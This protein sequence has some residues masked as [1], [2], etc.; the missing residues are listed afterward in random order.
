MF[1]TDILDNSNNSDVMQKKFII[2]TDTP[3]TF[4]LD[5][6]IVHAKWLQKEARESGKANLEIKTSY[7]GEGA[8]IRITIYTSN[9][10]KLAKI[11]GTVSI[12][13][14]RTMFNIPEKVNPGESLFFE[15]ILPKHGIS[16]KSD[17]IP[18]KPG[19]NVKNMRW[20]KQEVHRGEK[21]SIICEFD[22]GVTDNDPVDVKIFEYSDNN[23]HDRIT[24]IPA[25][26]S[27][28]KIDVQWICEY[29][30]DT[31]K[32]PTDEEL[33]KFGKQYKPPE[34]FF[35]VTLDSEIIGTNQKSG[36][37]RFRDNVELKITNGRIERD[38]AQEFVITLPD[39]SEVKRKPDSN[40]S[41]VIN[42]LDPGKIKISPTDQSASQKHGEVLWKTGSGAEIIF[43]DHT[44]LIDSHMH[45]QSNNCCPLTMQW[46]LLAISAG[47]RSNSDRKKLIDTTSNLIVSLLAT[48][49]LGKIGRLSSDLIARLYM[50]ELKDNDM[51]V[52]LSW[53]VLSQRKIENYNNNNQ[54]EQMRIIAGKKAEL[55]EMTYSSLTDYNEE[56][57]KETA[58]YFHGTRLVRM[59]F[60]MSMDM[61]YGSYWGRSGIPIYIKSDNKMLYINDFVSC[62]I[63]RDQPDTSFSVSLNEFTVT[64]C[65]ITKE[66]IDATKP[67]YISTSPQ[68][69]SGT[70]HLYP[71]FFTNEV[72]DTNGN[73]FYLHQFDLFN[74]SHMI[75]PPSDCIPLVKFQNTPETRTLAG[76]KYVH[77]VNI[78]PG[79]DDCRFE[80]YA[81][82]REFTIASA[83]RYP[84]S[85]FAFYHYD[86]RRHQVGSEGVT[87]RSL[88]EKLIKDHSFFTCKFNYKIFTQLE[89]GVSYYGAVEAFPHHQLNDIEY[90][91]SVI[92]GNQRSN[93][94]TFA[95]Q[96]LYDDN[97]SGLFWGMK[98]YPRLGY[99]P[100]DFDNYKNLKEFYRTCE[101][102]GIPI[103]IHCN[104]GGMSVPDYFLYE[105]YDHGNI[106]KEYNL[107]D[108][109]KYFDGTTTGT[110]SKDS[111]ARWAK[112]LESFPKLK[113]CLAHF[114]GC[115][116]WK[117][118]GNLK[119]TENELKMRKPCLG[120]SKYDHC[121][122][123]RDWIKSIAELISTKEN[124]YTDISYFV[125][126]NPSIF[127][128]NY[129]LEDVA[130][131][132]SWLIKQYK[133]LKDRILMGSDWY[134]IELEHDKG[135]GEYFTR[136]FRMLK[137]VSKEV[138]FDAW[139]Q[140]AVVN[141]LRYMGLIEERKESVGPFKID[142]GMLE[143]YVG[144]FD[145]FLNNTKT[146][147]RIKLDQK[148]VS[149]NTTTALEKIKLLNSI[150]DSADL[151]RK[152]NLI[153]LCE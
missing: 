97:G 122:K 54:T 32:I 60:A 106:K 126:D 134:M 66:Q 151:K 23:I 53:T 129:N 7:V 43:P 99:A 87:A 46:G 113:I 73:P 82:Q 31:D 29:R 16:K 110:E 88:A 40:G 128:I 145:N 139:H 26:I 143:R 37:L 83:I 91:E 125:N 136:M 72:Y 49:R 28:N 115:D 56:F 86:P 63:S 124:V 95:D 57:L 5:S 81:A 142:V 67:G 146:S 141:P 44:P 69:N 105:R 55:S 98:M 138:Q 75:K 100:D 109:E 61:S 130:K 21:V 38:N 94:Q 51:K 41:I 15:A 77:F 10:R 152:G 59:N 85:I 58:G 22:S 96:F 52:E 4:R 79:E 12:N 116:T 27:H 123:Y 8:E 62:D 1:K 137:Q 39:G 64:P 35:T 127:G 13:C 144:R 76:K 74:Y 17:S 25:K 9:G 131:N 34:F 103:T 30:K 153:I 92:S 14:F 45:I 90:M 50:N 121:D 71:H 93:E 36:L 107:H 48:G 108:A 101:S 18:V 47:S 118:A 140:F 117:E 150:P 20:D 149:K 65:I 114:G 84:L 3:V 78:A 104:A 111:P 147:K 120:S 42:S 2:Q 119:E 24:T 112:V 6:S 135:V 33:R 68:R 102:K 132:L 11:K 70:I 80:D 133:D 89:N 148:D 19:I